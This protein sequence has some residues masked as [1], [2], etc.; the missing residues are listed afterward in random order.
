MKDTY[1]ALAEDSGRLR[2]LLPK[3]E[4]GLDSLKSE[5]LG[6]E[7][8]VALAEVCRAAGN[9]SQARTFFEA[10]LARD[11]RHVVAKVGMGAL[12]AD[13]EAW[14]ESERWFLE[15]ARDPDAGALSRDAVLGLGAVY[16]RSSLLQERWL[17]ARTPDAARLVRMRAE[18]GSWAFRPKISLLMPHFNQGV[19]WLEAALDSVLAQVYPEWELCIADDASTDPRSR[20]VLERYAARDPRIRVRWL[21]RNQH[22]AGATNRALETATGDWIGFLDSDDALVPHTLWACVVAAQ[23]DPATDFV[24]SDNA[25]IDGKGKLTGLMLKPAWSPEFFLSTN[26]IVHFCVYSRRIVEAIGPFRED[27]AYRGVQDVDIK[28]RLL[29]LTDRVVFVPEV[30]YLWRETEGSVSSSARAKPYVLENARR[31]FQEVLERRGLPMRVEFPSIAER[32]GRGI[33]KIA[34]PADSDKKIAIV[35]PGAT[36]RQLEALRGCAGSARVEVVAD[37]KSVAATGAEYVAFVHP[38]ATPISSSWLA[39]LRGYLDLD[40]KIGVV[41]GKVV[42]AKKKVD[43]GAY[44]LLDDVHVANRGADHDS[45]GAYWFNNVIAH[46]V[47]AVSGACLMTRRDLFERLS[48]FRND[49]YGDLADVDYALRARDAGYRTVFNPWCE[50][51]VKKGVGR[52]A[53]DAQREALRRDHAKAFA[54]DPYCNPGYSRRL[55]FVFQELIDL[56]VPIEHL[57]EAPKARPQPKPVPAPERAPAPAP[58]PAPRPNRGR[59]L[60]IN[61]VLPPS[62]K[63]T[64][65][66][67]AILEYA[68]RLL[69]KGHDVSVT[70]YPDAYWGAPSPFPWFHFEGRLHYKELSGILRGD[71][72]IPPTVGGHDEVFNALL[73]RLLKMG[74]PQVLAELMLA[75][76]GGVQDKRTASLD[77]LLQLYLK[78]AW[79]MESM[80]ACDLNIATF[81]ETAFPVYFSRK[82]K[83]VYFMQHFEEVFYPN[84]FGAYPL[85]LAVRSSYGLPM[86]KVAN[87]SW[88][89][90]V[91]LDRYGQH[92]PFSNNGIELSDF[93]PR[94][95]DSATDG[96]LRVVTYSRPEEWKGFLD[97]AEA[98]RRVRR[99]WNGPVE[100]HVFGYRNPSAD[101]SDPSAPYVYHEGLSFK[102]LAD[103]YARCDVALCPSWYESFP[104]PP[105]EAM[106]SGTAVV[107]TAYGTEDYAFDRKTALVVPSRDVEKMAEAILE[108]FRD[109]QLRGELAEAGRREAERF[110]WD[111]AVDVRES[112]LL[113]IHDGR[114]TYDP[115]RSV[116]TGLFDEAG[117]E[118]ER[119]PA[120]VTAP[121]GRLVKSAERLSPSVFLV[122]DGCKRHLLDG[123]TLLGTAWEGTP[124]LELDAATLARI[125]TGSPIFG[126]ADL[127]AGEDVLAAR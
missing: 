125:P 105:L 8:C 53:T 10:A 77:H 25:V 116:K 113:D 37:A 92:V 4:R 99:R 9:R 66:P 3:L 75:V 54:S 63:I 79:L 81:W 43:A 110:E 36:P 68:N 32:T 97:A 91:M 120:D 2:R 115:F 35:A 70:T 74:G 5:T 84:V 112:I 96:T 80:P 124:V 52:F 40:A 47:S 61:F 73:T 95:K 67:L 50:L 122:Q 88:L 114:T 31:T 44:V 21:E 7:T 118:F 64:G 48:G 93:A 20:A 126:A 17:K 87:S 15:A 108:L 69:A 34:F 59:R 101:P 28:A 119:A 57:D 62:P 76:G 55:P 111:R 22:I 14:A 121:E 45:I 23:A 56:G 83:P 51:L 6:P 123:S 18:Q 71:A 127:P 106:A 98:M 39:E 26:Y 65:G 27:D 60:R 1:T 117:I 109:T 78:T 29:D 72:V 85:K 24:Y 41:G 58:A 100:W 30:L 13:A 49:L 90:K 89:Q 104:L 12:A 82:G 42:D 86:Y 102:D 11:P 103:L 38:D 46:N 33:Y 107:T 16:R 94:A 19:A